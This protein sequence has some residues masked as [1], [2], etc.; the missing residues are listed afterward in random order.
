MNG[1][2]GSC[3]IGQCL[4]NDS[5][6]V[7]VRQ[8]YTEIERDVPTHGSSDTASPKANCAKIE[9]HVSTAMDG[10]VSE[11]TVRCRLEEVGL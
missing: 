10:P 1:I 7:F 8:Q 5:E 3:E 2:V 4:E 11:E 9:R 6:L